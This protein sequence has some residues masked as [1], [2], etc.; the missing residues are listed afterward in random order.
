MVPILVFFQS[1]FDDLI[2]VLV[3]PKWWHFKSKSQEQEL[4][5][6]EPINTG[7]LPIIHV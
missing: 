5:T 6:L 7:N 3:P 2:L 4:E 1:L